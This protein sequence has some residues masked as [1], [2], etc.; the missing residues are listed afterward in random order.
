MGSINN[1]L[2]NFLLLFVVGINICGCALM[3]Y[4]NDF[5]CPIPEGQKCKSLYE[6]NKMTDQG[7]FD[8]NNRDNEKSN[9]K[10]QPNRCCSKHGNS[11]KITNE[12]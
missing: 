5:D 9:K 11:R 8:P 6:I 3:P 10:D 7:M 1:Q 2:I 12:S 4:K